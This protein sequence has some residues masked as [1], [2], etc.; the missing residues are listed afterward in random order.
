MHPALVPTDKPG[1]AARGQIES[2]GQLIQKTSLLNRLKRSLLI[3]GQHLYQ[4]LFFI[5]QT[6]RRYGIESPA[7]TGFNTQIAIDEDILSGCIRY[8]G[9]G[10]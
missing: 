10:L 7:F 3:T 5:T 9:Y 8:H 2:A 6:N 4:G 1:Y